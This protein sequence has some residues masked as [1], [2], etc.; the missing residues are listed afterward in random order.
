MV[1]L[2]NIVIQ[3]ISKCVENLGFSSDRRQKVLAVIHILPTCSSINW[4][5]VKIMI[6]NFISSHRTTH[7][8][9]SPRLWWWHIEPGEKYKYQSVW[10]RLVMLKHGINSAMYYWSNRGRKIINAFLN[11]IW[12]FHTSMMCESDLIQSNVCYVIFE[13]VYF[14]RFV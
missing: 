13:A 5:L 14:C 4:C 9:I 6:K 11:K 10:A 2:S 7:T 8:V 1:K 12:M 3:Y